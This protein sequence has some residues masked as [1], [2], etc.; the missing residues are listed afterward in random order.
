MIVT[1][2][3][4]TYQPDPSA[5]NT[6]LFIGLLVAISALILL[7]VGA[8]R[9]HHSMTNPVGFVALGLA[10]VIELVGF[11]VL[12]PLAT[13]QAQDLQFHEE[14]VVQIEAVE[15]AFPGVPHNGPTVTPDN[16]GAG[17]EFI[18]TDATGP[19]LV[20]VTPVTTTSN[21]R[22]YRISLK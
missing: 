14:Q 9:G 4:T 13:V 6:V 15:K 10:M 19:H 17:A 11:L 18:I 8:V 3:Y 7:V 12:A 16:V 1:V 5:S 2:P 21:A 20:T 22:D